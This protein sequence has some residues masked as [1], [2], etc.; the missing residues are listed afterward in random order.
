MGARALEP[1]ARDELRRLG[2]RPRRSAR[3]GLASLT[4][5]ERHVAELAA[6]GLSTPQIATHLH[7]SRNTVETHL[8]HVYQKLEVSGR[9]ELGTALTELAQRV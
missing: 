4:P 2:L 7:V 9:R 5:S 1:Q 3:T 8:R 6:E